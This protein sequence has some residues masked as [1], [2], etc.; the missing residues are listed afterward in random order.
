MRNANLCLGE[1]IAQL[2]QHQVGINRDFPCYCV[3]LVTFPPRAFGN[4]AEDPVCG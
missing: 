2:Q 4:L 1:V 3:G